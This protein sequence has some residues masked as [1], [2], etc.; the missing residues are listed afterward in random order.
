MGIDRLVELKCWFFIINQ[1]PHEKW[2]V[3][4]Q[5]LRMGT[6][7][8]SGSLDRAARHGAVLLRG[9]SRRFSPEL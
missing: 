2:L 8:A 1:N 9:H 7:V 4:G 3:M 6:V 5:S